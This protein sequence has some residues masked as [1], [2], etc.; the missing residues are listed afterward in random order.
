MKKKSKLRKFNE[1]K[2]SSVG[3]VVVTLFVL[4]M[5]TLIYLNV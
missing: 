3:Y 1:V 2:P 5:S 4:V